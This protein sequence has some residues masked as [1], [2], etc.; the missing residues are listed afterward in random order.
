MDGAVVEDPP[1]DLQVVQ[2]RERRVARG[3]L[4]TLESV[5]IHIFTN[6]PGNRAVQ[7]HI[8]FVTFIGLGF[9]D[10]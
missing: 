1:T 2:G 3:G 10:S 6:Y 9:N 7:D 8:M 4:N 5:Q